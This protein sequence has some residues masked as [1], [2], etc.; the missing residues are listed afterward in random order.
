MGKI[1]QTQIWQTEPECVVR[2]LFQILFVLTQLDP[3][4]CHMFQHRSC[5]FSLGR[6][7]TPLSYHLLGE[8]FAFSGWFPQIHL[9]LHLPVRCHHKWPHSLQ[10]GTP[11]PELNSLHLSAHYS[12]NQGKSSLCTLYGYICSSMLYCPNYKIVN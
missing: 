4:E 12:T 9:C 3:N 1:H 11:S 8:E 10:E 6:P 2:E 5:V 7:S